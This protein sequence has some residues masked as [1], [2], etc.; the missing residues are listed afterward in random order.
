MKTS[1]KP[2]LWFSVL[3]AILHLVMIIVGAVNKGSGNY[4]AVFLEAIG[5]IC[6]VVDILNIVTL[7][8]QSK[9]PPE[10]PP[11]KKEHSLRC[12]H[13][14]KW[15]YLKDGLYLKHWNY[16]NKKGLTSDFKKEKGI[17]N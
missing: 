9:D 14:G 1:S 11:E 6:F 5:S 10:P 4:P 17:P 3:E 16:L 12:E 8:Y 15:L 2:S 13:C 7:I